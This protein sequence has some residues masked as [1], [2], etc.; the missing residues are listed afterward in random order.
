ML[1][2]SSDDHFATGVYRVTTLCTLSLP[3]IMC[4]LYV[5][6]TGKENELLRCSVQVASQGVLLQEEPPHSFLWLGVPPL[7][8]GCGQGWVNEWATMSVASAMMRKS[9]GSQGTTASKY[10]LHPSWG[11]GRQGRG[12]PRRISG[13]KHSAVSRKGQIGCRWVKLV[14]HSALDLS[15]PAAK[16]A[17][18]CSLD[19]GVHHC[20][21]RPG[22]RTVR[23]I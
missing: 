23:C 3:G 11:R 18:K 21:E 2:H 1:A 20:W 12:Y 4:R 15:T 5:S 7:G 10:F 9:P 19:A 17:E 22:E 16:E 8:R 13:Q 14:H 6:Q